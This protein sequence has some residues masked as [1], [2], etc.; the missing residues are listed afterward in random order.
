MSDPTK[1]IESAVRLLE[2]SLKLILAPDSHES[3]TNKK[4]SDS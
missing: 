1:V 4:P 2:E 3:T